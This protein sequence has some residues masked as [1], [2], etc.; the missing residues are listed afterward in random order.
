[1]SAAPGAG[2]CHRILHA[3]ECEGREDRD[4]CG[5]SASDLV[6]LLLLLYSPIYTAQL[7]I[8][9]IAKSE[10]SP[11]GWYTLLYNNSHDVKI[12]SS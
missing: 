6:Q 2:G 3:G 7:I 9:P 1:M 8:N 12:Q 11:I 10:E 5:A 4:L